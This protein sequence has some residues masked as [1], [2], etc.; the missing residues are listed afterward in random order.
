MSELEAITYVLNPSPVTRKQPG[1]LT[2]SF[3]PPV[4]Q[5][6][7]AFHQS[8]PRYNP[9]PLVSLPH[10]AQSLQLKNI[11]IKDESYRFN[12]NAFKVLGAGYALAHA[13]SVKLGIDDEVP[14]FEMFRSQSARSKLRDI[15]VITATDGNH[16]RAVAWSA[17][18][19]GCKAVIYMPKHTSPARIRN[20]ESHG[21]TVRIID[22]NYDAAV[23]AASSDAEQNDWMLIQDTSWTGYERIPFRIMQGY[24]TIAVEAMEQL[25]GCIPTH[26]FLQC[27]VGSFAAS[28]Q[29]YFIERYGDNRCPFS[30]IVEPA[31]AA[32]F[33]HSMRENTGSPVTI[34]G[35]LDT[36]MAGLA[37]GE[38]SI[39]AWEIL[40]NHA[41]AFISCRDS[42]AIKGMRTLGIPLSGDPRIISGESGAVTLGLLVHLRT[43][44]LNDDVTE[45]LQLNSHSRV[46]LI[47][48][49]G[50]TDPEAYRKIIGGE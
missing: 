29:A 11:W 22:D 34:N 43:H 20:I 12:L 49:E 18:H 35:D 3:S 15:T 7:R 36:I 42:I 19:M 26:I 14:S 5:S 33:H 8:I 2:Q 41:D 28:M 9:T 23:R 40:K 1:G 30:A 24:L 46:L 21:A 10:L 39:L 38:P 47:S 45:A 50:D 37:C 32:C 31:R 4:P 6:V 48:T 13:L 25:D 16:G 17:Q 27:G 44:L